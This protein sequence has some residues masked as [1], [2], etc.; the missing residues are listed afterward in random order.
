MK[1]N[2][3]DFAKTAIV[4]SKARIAVMQLIEAARQSTKNYAQ[5]S[6]NFVTNKPT[7]IKMNKCIFPKDF[8]P[9]VAHLVGRHG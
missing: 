4:A 5:P 8:T 1:E 3:L 7:V 6:Q 9:T 2:L